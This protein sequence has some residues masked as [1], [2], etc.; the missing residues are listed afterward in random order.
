LYFIVEGEF[1]LTRDQYLPDDT[2]DNKKMEMFHTMKT[3]K[4]F[5]LKI[6]GV[7]ECMGLEEFISGE[8]R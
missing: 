3:N 4:T 1:K 8:K 5:E 6:I 7:N 2:V